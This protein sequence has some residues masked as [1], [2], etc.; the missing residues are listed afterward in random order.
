MKVEVVLNNYLWLKATDLPMEIVEDIQRNLTIPNQEK[1][2]AQKQHL[3]GAERLPDL[4]TLY[5]WSGEWII[6]P[7]GF[8]KRLS[9]G[10]QSI[11][12]EVQLDNHMVNDSQIYYS[13]LPNLRDY[14]AEAVKDLKYFAQGI[15]EAPTGSGKT[16]TMLALIAEIGT[17][18]LVIVNKKELLQQWKDRAW[19]HLGVKTGFIGDNRWEEDSITIATQQ[20]LWARRDELNGWW[21]FWGMVI[22]DECHSVQAETYHEVMEKFPAQYRYGV[23]ATPRKT[24]HF[25]IAESVL[26]P[27]IHKTAKQPLRDAGYLVTPKVFVIPTDFYYPFQANE[28]SDQGRL[29][30]RNN[31]HK[32]LDKL[33][34]DLNR[35]TLI[36]ETAK[37]LPGRCILILSKRLEHIAILKE[38][39]ANTTHDV[40]LLTGSE[41]LEQRMEVYERA[42]SGNCIIL[43]T[44]ADEA[45]DIPESTPSFSVFQ[46]R[47]P[48]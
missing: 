30:K 1:I 26:G 17:P 8:Y 4:V 27:I 23:S 39:L 32:V 7:R 38:M 45:V 34:K 33:Q 43:S 15:Y 5:K 29:T 46:L 40:L 11:G 37:S 24:G 13:M 16:V 48:I 2:S 35:N 20:T 12:H 9:D 6:L 21:D 41:K 3:W 42:S 10:L 22:L 47:T 18:T 44:L 14:Q 25:K 36:A 31:Y 19:E 28:V